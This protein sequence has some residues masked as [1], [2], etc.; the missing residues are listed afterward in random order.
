M[1]TRRSVAALTLLAVA[2]LASGC[3]AQT[4]SAPRRL[5]SDFAQAVA[6]QDA[7]KACALLA[8]ETRSELEQSAGEACVK[9]LGSEDLQSPGALRHFA[10]F[11]TMAQATFAGDVVF[12]A[13]FKSGWRVMAAGCTPQPERPYDCQLQGG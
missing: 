9:A 2:V 5:A 13:E 1:R 8:P 10:S 4:E 3:G 11:G 7:A 12:L 6:A